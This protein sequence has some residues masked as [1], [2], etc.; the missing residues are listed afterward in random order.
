MGTTKGTLT[1]TVDAV[2]D[3]S[4][5]AV[6]GLTTSASKL[7]KDPDAL[8]RWDQG[9]AD[10]HRTAMQLARSALAKMPYPPVTD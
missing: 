5:A 2:T 3:T 7:A 4:K 6:S 8:R 1:M 10:R 9:I